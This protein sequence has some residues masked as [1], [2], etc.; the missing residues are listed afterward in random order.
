MFKIKHNSIIHAAYLM[1]V[2]IMTIS[3]VHVVSQD[4]SKKIYLGGGKM[5]LSQPNKTWVKGNEI[6]ISKLGYLAKKQSFADRI[7]LVIIDLRIGQEKI[8]CEVSKDSRLNIEIKDD[9]NVLR[10]QYKSD[11]TDKW[12]ENLYFLTSNKMTTLEARDGDVGGVSV[13]SAAGRINYKTTN[14]TNKVPLLYQCDLDG[15]NS[16]LLMKGAMPGPWSPDGKWYLILKSPDDFVYRGNEFNK[17]K[18]TK[19]EVESLL[20]KMKDTTSLPILQVYDQ[21]N[22]KILELFEVLNPR[23]EWSPDSKSLIVTSK[24]GRSFSVVEF[25][26][27]DSQLL[28]KRISGYHDSLEK[29]LFA[30]NPTWSP[31]GAQI[32][33]VKGRDDGQK[34]LTQ[35]LWICDKYANNQY[36]L[37]TTPS[38]FELAGTWIENDLV[39]IRFQP[40]HSVVDVMRFETS[41]K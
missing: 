7:Q 22:S 38:L 20:S 33:Y 6:A 39:V 17:G 4:I 37:T 41:T 14:N 32:C 5:L 23:M 35:D 21:N 15:K 10:Y 18:I 24:D 25:E 16:T 36:A 19:E 11:K 31:N 2:P 26:S 9:G 34:I 13:S 3:N 1:I 30:N 29:G 27:I 12:I 28:V 40:D 8:V